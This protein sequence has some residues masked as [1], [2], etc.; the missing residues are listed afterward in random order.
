[1]GFISVLLILLMRI[2]DHLTDETRG[3]STINRSA[4]YENRHVTANI[5]LSS[6]SV[7]FSVLPGFNHHPLALE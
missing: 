2:L 6:L 4:D 5:F 7:C 1:M 3:Q